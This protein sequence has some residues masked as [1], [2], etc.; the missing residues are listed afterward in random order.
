MMKKLVTVLGILCFAFTVNAQT[1]KKAFTISGYG[2]LYYAYDFDKP[3]NNRRPN[4]I[5]SHN[6]HNEVTVNL[7]MLKGNYEEGRVR[8]NL[9]LMTGTYANANLSTEPGVLK[10]IYEAN[11]GIRLHKNKEIWLDAGVMPSH[12]GAEGAISMDYPTLT[13]SLFAEGSPYYESGVCL[14]YKNVSETWYLALLYL[15]GWQ[16]IQRQS[17][18]STPSGG[19]QITYTP[20]DKITVNWSTFV[21]SITPDVSRRMRYFSDLYGIVKIGKK[22]TLTALF[23]FGSDQSA[24]GSSNYYGWYTVAAILQYQL[25]NNASITARGEYF[26]D[27]Y[28]RVAGTPIFTDFLVSGYSL[29]YNYEVMK[30]V[31]WRTEAKYY[32]SYDPIFSG[33]SLSKRDNLLFTTSL[34]VRFK[35]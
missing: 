10:N 32:N 20:N 26:Q 22:L 6:R 3:L 15:N 1:E 5:Y 18:N 9:A 17:G 19:T 8:A 2:E 31:M 21:G 24:K 34:A 28:N 11:V 12:L 7:A 16:T 23:D 25:N 29:G 27:A 30:G 35:R 4:Y 13:R 14:S 33:N